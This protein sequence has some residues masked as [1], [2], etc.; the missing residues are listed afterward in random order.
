MKSIDQYKE[1]AKTN[2]LSL[3][4]LAHAWCRTRC[5]IPSTIIGATTIKQLEE[6]I[7]AFCVRL[8]NA[9]LKKIDEIHIQCLDPYMTL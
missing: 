1:I 6:N 8:D 9:T 3:A 5:F 4:T 7:D 2:N